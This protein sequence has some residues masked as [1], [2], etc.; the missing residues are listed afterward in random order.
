MDRKGLVVD[1]SGFGD[2][3]EGILDDYFSQADHVA[4]SATQK[5]GR[6]CVRQPEPAAFGGYYVRVYN[7]AKPSL[8]HLLEFGHEK[9]VHGVD[10]GGRVPARPHIAD[11]AD[12]GAEAVMEAMRDG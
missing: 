11:A 6:E 8:T 9:W 4:K 10:T 3:F 5:G 1:A 12:R 2:A 7:D